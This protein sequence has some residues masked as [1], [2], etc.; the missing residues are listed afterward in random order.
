MAFENNPT[1]T[2]T[3]TSDSVTFT[4]V[5]V[6]NAFLRWLTDGHAKKYSPES[7]IACMEK[8]SEY[9]VRKKI[10]TISLWSITNHRL[11][12]DIYNKII[13]NKLF[14]I[15]DKKTHAAFTHS[16]RSVVCICSF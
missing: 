7:S 3:C 6:S 13:A 2:N 14:R 11:F 12:G 9:A 15:T 16:R 10:L 4:A 1:K 8:V 5:E